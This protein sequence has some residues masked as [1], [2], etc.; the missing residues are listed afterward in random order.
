MVEA[1]LWGLVATSSLVV[2][3]VLGIF[4]NISQKVLGAVMA[5]GA[6]VLISAVSYE[7]VYEAVTL[8]KWSGAPTAG[9]A[10][11]ALT[12]FLADRWIGK[13]TAIWGNYGSDKG[14]GRPKGE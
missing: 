8:G 1:F 9:L 11:G 13:L 7:L 4:F 5:F 3:G 10:I 12:F 14:Y 6:G 2:G